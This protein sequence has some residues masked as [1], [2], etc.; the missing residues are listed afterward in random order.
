MN[1]SVVGTGYV[2]LVA[3]TCFADRGNRVIC[4]D[5]DEAKIEA[6]KKGEVPIY[7]PGL[8]EILQRNLKASRLATAAPTCRRC[9]RSPRRSVPTWTATGSS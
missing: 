2:G 6:L 8:A 4:V 1:L 9:C 3:G 5:V 7:E